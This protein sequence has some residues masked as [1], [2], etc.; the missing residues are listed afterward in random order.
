[1]PHR[2][3]M[4][5]GLLVISY[6]IVFKFLADVLAGGFHDSVQVR[7]FKQSIG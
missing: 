6:V 3:V 7:A 4:A 2:H 1:M 5:Q